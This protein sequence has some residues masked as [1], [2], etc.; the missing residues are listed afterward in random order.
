MGMA[1]ISIWVCRL[2]II[3]RIQLDLFREQTFLLVSTLGLS[4]ALSEGVI[5]ELIK[6]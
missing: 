6:S 2:A 5:E 1:E 4:N 3:L